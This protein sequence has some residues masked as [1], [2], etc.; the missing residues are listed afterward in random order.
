M[1]DRLALVATEAAEDVID[2]V[3]AIGAPDANPDP[4]ELRGADGAN[5][6][7]QATM[8][9]GRAVRPDPD[10]ADR[11]VRI[12]IDHDQAAGRQRVPVEER[13]D[14]ATAEVHEG[15]RLHQRDRLAGNLSLANPRAVPGRLDRDP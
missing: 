3:A 8:S 2:E 12:I 15:E 6:G 10:L 14:R 13:G 1:L 7:L 5:D 9:A 11:Q 4:G